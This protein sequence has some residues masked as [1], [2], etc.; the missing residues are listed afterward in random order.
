MGRVA[1]GN[2]AKTCISW[3]N[4]LFLPIIRNMDIQSI[5]K[6][7]HDVVVSAL[8]DDSYP[9]AY[10]NICVGKNFPFSNDEINDGFKKLKWDSDISTADLNIIRSTEMEDNALEVTSMNEF[11]DDSGAGKT[12]FPKKE[13]A[14]LRV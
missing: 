11:V 8:P 12:Y 13:C 2:G 4:R 10:I 7:I 5:Y 3:R 14:V 1:H 6:H 9:L